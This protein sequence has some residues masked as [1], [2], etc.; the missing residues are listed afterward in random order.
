MVVTVEDY[1]EIRRLH[2][3]EGMSQRQ[4][5]KK[6][7]ISRN[8]V[9]KYCDGN[10]VPWERS[11]YT[12]AP[13]I[14]TERVLAFIQNCLEQDK[15]SGTAK[16]NHTA[17]RIYDRLVSE[18]GFAGSESTIRRTVR[19][20]RQKHA[21]VYIPL[22][23]SPGEAMQVDWGQAL[24]YCNGVRSIVN[25]FCARLCSSCAPIV[26]AYERQNEESF[27]DAFVKTF[28]YFSGVPRKVFFDNA[29]VAVKDGFGAHAKK[30][31]GYAALAAHYGF[32][33]VFCNPASG[34]EKG[35]VV[36]LVG[37]A[38]RN[39]LVPIPRINAFS[40][41]NESLEYRSR[42]YLNHFIRGKQASVGTMYAVE[43]ASLLALPGYVY[44]VSKSRNVRVDNYSTIRF[45]TN[46]YSVPVKCCG[47]VVSVKGY[48][49]R[50]LVFYQGNK[51][52][53]HQ[54]C[55]KKNQSIYKL[56]HYLPIL[57]KKGRAVFNAKPVR[58]SL[59]AN[60]IN[61]MQK[62]DFTHKQLMEILYKCANQGWESVW[63]Q[64]NYLQQDEDNMPIIQDIVRVQPVNLANYDILYNKKAGVC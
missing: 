16:Q 54:R 46:N 28:Q 32:E 11:E 15:D 56:E 44:D 9:K 42:A 3:I 53:E 35:L 48:A 1:K 25:L 49:D 37:W 47:Y 64:Q 51:I 63:H 60:F 18:C 17:K 24:V 13:A 20:L 33:A 45:D 36:G 31:A 52:A 39:I 34:N 5:A 58:Q 43:Q 6:L 10:A 59:P 61:W 55:Y 21:E 29:K 4:I 14:V 12:R 38:R 41:L 2:L 7:N 22:E 27:L 19:S 62:K 8:T 50:I 23:F 40:D 30:Q 26:F 57:E